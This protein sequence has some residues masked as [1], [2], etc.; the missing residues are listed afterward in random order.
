M[1]TFRKKIQ[2]KKLKFHTD[3][4]EIHQKDAEGLFFQVHVWVF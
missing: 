1:S 3:R 2:I 4:F